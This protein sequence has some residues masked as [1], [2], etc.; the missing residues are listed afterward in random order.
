MIVRRF[1]RFPFPLLSVVLLALLAASSP[2]QSPDPF[3]PPSDAALQTMQ[4][5]IDAMGYSYTVGPT[6]VYDLSPEEKANMFRLRR[7]PRVDARSP[8][9][10]PLA[11][12]MVEPLPAQLDW[13]DRDGRTYVNPI[14]NQGECGSCYAFGAAAAAEGAYNRHY[15]LVNEQR[16]EFSEAFIAFCLGNLYPGFDGCYG[17]N[18]DY[19][20][21]QALCEY[22]L[23]EEI[24]Y[25]YSDNPLQD[26][27]ASAWDTP[28]TRFTGW[29]RA[30]CS[31]VDAIKRAIL[32]YG[33][34]DAAVMVDAFFEAYQSGI[35]ENDDTACDQGAYT[36]TNHAIALVGW[37]DNGDAENNGYWILRNSWGENWG[38]NGYMRIRYGSARVD[39]AVAYLGPPMEHAL[40]P[41]PV[42]V[43]LNSL[44]NATQA[45][46]PVEV[47]VR[48]NGLDAMEIQIAASADWFDVT[49]ET[50]TA[51][52]QDAIAFQLSLNAAAAHLVAGVYE[53]QIV[54]RDTAGELLFSIP[55]RLTL[56][57]PLEV[58]PAQIFHDIHMGA[59]LDLQLSGTF[60]LTNNTSAPIHWTALAL[61]D[62]V[63]IAPAEGEL[64]GGATAATI[65]YVLDRDTVADADTL[66]GE[67]GVFYNAGEDAILL[68]MT[69]SVWRR[70]EDWRDEC[71][72]TW[73]PRSTEV[74]LR[75]DGIY[76]PEPGRGFT[77]KVTGPR[78]GMDG[79][80]LPYIHRIAL[81]G[82][83]A[84]V[85][86]DGAIVHNLECEGTLN[87]LV[88]R[89][90]AVYNTMVG[91]MRQARLIA[92]RILS[93]DNL[94]A[95]NPEWSGRLTVA[96]AATGPLDVQTLGMA[97][98]GMSAPGKTLRLLGSAKRWPGRRSESP[99]IHRPHL[100]GLQWEV[101]AI[102]DIRLVGADVQIVT[103]RALHAA[104]A[105]RVR[106]WVQAFTVQGERDVAGGNI[107]IR[108][109]HSAA[110]QV[111]MVANGGALG[112]ER[113]LADGAIGQLTAR[114]RQFRIAGEQGV[115]GGFLG[116][117]PEDWD[118]L[119][120]FDPRPLETTMGVVSG[121]GQLQNE[122]RLLRG[123][124]GIAAIF[125]AGAERITPERGGLLLRPTYQGRIRQMRTLPLR[126]FDQGE[127][128][129]ISGALH[130][131]PAAG[132]PHLIGDREAVA[133]GR[134]EVFTSPPER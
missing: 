116:I 117:D 99:V 123:D 28:R 47:T 46:E 84:R 109:F 31:D 13:R 65:Q 24:D 16:I 14:R 95:E 38:E 113:L 33:V 121:L 61:P 17:A 36:A 108:D 58:A 27:L 49:P 125:V 19:Q 50:A 15:D 6:W 41:E 54:V 87:R 67:I 96:P 52:A 131:S 134:L 44:T 111:D 9:V 85:M 106:A 71:R 129:T 79:A 120:R 114:A 94:I 25:P 86:I 69:V 22:G 10:G 70:T 2:G 122:M 110:R 55:V 4:A 124:M 59:N 26:C 12:R 89:Q 64:A 130:L 74:D 5:E 102:R 100:V 40:F 72:V 35:F 23:V 73:S 60:R 91:D 126:W 43:S 92:P 57:D 63:H 88:A 101:G 103:L 77:L 83:A 127:Q 76:V 97:L 48:N 18:Y 21:L 53:E 39:C 93:Y 90:G 78:T 42:R 29:Y 105:S 45:L 30:P 62:W 51:P 80:P 11:R 68:P 34:V 20:E 1:S 82:D 128:P 107:L 104:P 118:F 37:D 66:D 75:E 81:G 112:A 32:L 7:I 119:S 132:M 8:R 133:E 115:F 98:T 3:A 56:K